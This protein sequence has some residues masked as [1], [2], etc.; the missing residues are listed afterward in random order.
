MKFPI[1]VVLLVFC[2]SAAE[3]SCKPDEEGN[4]A[5]RNELAKAIQKEFPKAIPFDEYADSLFFFLY[6]VHNVS[7]NQI[8][9]GQSTCM[10]DVINTKTPFKDHAVQGPFNLGG[11]GG[12]PFTGITGLNAF[13]HHVL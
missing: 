10:D 4:R 1:S 3:H 11:L 6:A 8:L 12:L 9:I 5:G 7:K 2:L 13:A